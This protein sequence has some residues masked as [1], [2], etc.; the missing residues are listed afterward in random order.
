V[1][2]GGSSPDRGRDREW[3]ESSAAAEYA[4]VETATRARLGVDSY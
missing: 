3:S 4:A 2:R 1:A